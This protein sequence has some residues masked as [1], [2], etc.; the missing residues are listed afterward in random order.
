MN[1]DKA[2]HREKLG[3]EHMLKGADGFTVPEGYFDALPERVLKR[4][5]RYCEEQQSYKRNR[6]R[7]WGMSVWMKAASILLLMGL[8]L[9]WWQRGVVEGRSTVELDS[10]SDEAVIEYLL[11]EGMRW[12][13]SSLGWKILSFWRWKEVLIC[14]KIVMP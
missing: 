13:M 3:F 10:V 6:L 5:K 12:R 9:W 4:W 14:N 11:E 8:A 1:R 7:R 2:D